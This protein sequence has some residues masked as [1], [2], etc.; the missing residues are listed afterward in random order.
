MLS[1]IRNFIQVQR[2]VSMEQLSREFSIAVEALE[3]ILEFWVNR[4][5][6][7]K[8]NQQKDCGSGCRTCHSKQITYYEWCF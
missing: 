2:V 6:I 5:V 3:P 8:A 7:R 4:G 1:I